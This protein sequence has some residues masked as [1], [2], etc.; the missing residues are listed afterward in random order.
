MTSAEY[1]ELEERPGRD[2]LEYL[3]IPLRYPKAFLLPFVVCVGLAVLLAWVAPRKYRS[4]TLILVE[5]KTLAES[6]VTP[7][8]AEGM[9]QRLN[10]IRQVVMSRTRLEE[11]IKKLDP[12]PEM[13]GQP[14]H[15]VVEAMRRGIEIR[16]QG[17]DSFVIEYVNKDPYKAMMVTSLLATQFTEDAATLRETLTQKA[18]T[19][20][21]D[22][23]TDARKALDEREAA[24]RQHRLKYT[25]SLPEQLDT[26]LRMLQQAQ[27]EQHTLSENLRTLEDRR[28][29]TERN[30]IE[31]RRLGGATGGAG[32][33]VKLRTTYAALRGRYTEE[34][35]DMRAMRARMEEI[36]KRLR[37]T[38]EDGTPADSPGTADPEILSLSQS[39]RL[40]E[41]D[42]ES[43]R[44]RRERLD[45]RIADLQRRVEDTPRAE[46]ELSSLTR[47]YPQ[48]RESY[49]AALRKE[50]DAEMA[51]R[52]EEYWRGGYFRVLDPAHLPRRPIR[53][54]GTLFLTAGLAIGFVL[55]L[56]ATVVSDL[57]DRS[58]KSERELEELLGREPIVTLPRV[59]PA[60]G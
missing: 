17:A 8:T 26:N 15:V 42:I 18:F 14:S 13:A 27:L 23:L 2:V 45:G 19:F 38:P 58:V 52:L 20:I 12:Y 50:M 35:P 25:G 43:L 56:G 57:A 4:G 44:Q 41:A 9:A 37:A 40:V 34:H 30:L 29:A 16:V 21:E 53:P 55:G 10:T 60:R 22:N 51:R 33:L 39:L 54:Y 6:F 24:L 11:V 3:E 59:A 7:V 49:N 31:G 36:E 5:S 48:L 46:Q 47:D 1:S 32:E 28:A